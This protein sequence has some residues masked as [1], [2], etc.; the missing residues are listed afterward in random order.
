MSARMHHRPAPVALA[1]S[2]AVTV[3]VA[4]RGAAAQDAAPAPDWAAVDA[5]MGR[6]GADQPGG[7]H[8]F[9]M[10]RG[11]LDVTVRSRS[12]APVRVRPALALGAWL[13]M[14]PTEHGVL[15]MGDLV[16]RDDEV[17][18]VL[19]ALQA[20]GVEQTAIHHH[21]LGETPRI[22]YV[23][24]H[25]HGDAVKIA[26]AVRDA[27][28]QTGTPPERP[29]AAAPAEPVP[30]DTAAIARALGRGGRLNGGVYQVS[31]PR[32]E[33]I[34]DGDV[35]LPAS[36]GLATA[37]NFQPTTAG[38]AATTGDFVLTAGEVNPVIRALSGHGIAVTSL[39]NHLLTD[40]PR[41]FF[42]HFWAEGDAAALA[43]GLRAGLDAT[44]VAR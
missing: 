40:E 9:S 21:L 18:K 42:M 38:R 8:R 36:M 2:I 41:L 15:A 30:L 32:A 14:L 13:A 27:L 12:G 24:V 10:P 28:A 22:L 1:L 19:A 23:H 37:I 34:R 26:G 29:A 4:P 31:V 39:H 11:D 44:N 3:L 20:G 5:A 25:G 43:T 17:A 6:K 35:S 33:A 16:L 7:V